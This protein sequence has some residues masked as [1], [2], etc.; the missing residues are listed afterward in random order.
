MSAL[1]GALRYS[2][3]FDLVP[4]DSERFIFRFMKTVDKERAFH[5]Q[6]VVIYNPLLVIGN[7]DGICEVESVIL[8]EF[9]CW[10]QVHMKLAH[11]LTEDLAL[12]F[13]REVGHENFLLPTW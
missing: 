4:R 13:L 8:D 10:V 7:W 9:L 1:P 2:R 11:L 6:P 5:K 12:D 3:D